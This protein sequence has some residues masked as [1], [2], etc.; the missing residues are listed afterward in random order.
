MFGYFIIPL[1]AHEICFKVAD[2]YPGLLL[3]VVSYIIYSQL[4]YVKRS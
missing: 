1:A 2:P 4:N 3:L